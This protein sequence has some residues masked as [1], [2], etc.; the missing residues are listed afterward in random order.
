MTITHSRITAPLFALAVAA[1][2]LAG[3]DGK[4]AAVPTPR[5]AA[6]GTHARLGVDAGSPGLALRAG[7]TLAPPKV[8]DLGSEPVGIGQVVED[9]EGAERR[10]D[11]GTQVTFALQAKVLFAKDSARL[12]NAA[13]SRIA[14]V[15]RGIDPR[16]GTEVRVYGF[17]DDLGSSAHGDALSRQ[18]A[19]AVQGVVAEELHG[20]TVTFDVRGFGE[21]HPVASNAGEAGR[22]QNRRVEISFSRAADAQGSFDGV[23]TL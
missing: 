18:R 2:V 19:V 7:A 1:S 5:S 16:P 14:A 21:R 11:T 22:Q 15:A 20:T 17:T 9:Q 10:E 8:L 3:S 23:E 12:S 4:S 6:S 13:R